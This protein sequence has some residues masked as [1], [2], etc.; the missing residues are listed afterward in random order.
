M[1]APAPSLTELVNGA[2]GVVVVLSG[3]VA[4]TTRS[5]A[6]LRRLPDKAVER[7]RRSASSLAPPPA[8]PCWSSACQEGNLLS[9]IKS[10]VTLFAGILISA[11]AVGH[12]LNP[13]EGGP[14]DFLAVV[15]YAIFLGACIAHQVAREEGVEPIHRAIRRAREA[16]DDR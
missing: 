10:W 3:I 6:V 13:V 9:V 8:L 1:S 7:A 4:A 5:I 14:R 11:A 15:L 16:R 12:F 2:A